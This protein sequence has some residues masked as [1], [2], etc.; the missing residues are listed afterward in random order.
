MEEAYDE[1][2]L[3]VC[4]RVWS[5]AQMCMNLIILRNGGNDYKLPHVGKLKVA[6]LIG[7]DFPTML[8]CQ[9]I[10]SNED[11]TEAAIAAFVDTEDTNNGTFVCYCCVAVHRPPPIF[12]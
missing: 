9:A 2:P 3:D 10:I 11:I 8:P 1:L 12:I 4:K 7:R 6:R 5:T